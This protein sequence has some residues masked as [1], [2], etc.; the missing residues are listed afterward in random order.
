MREKQILLDRIADIARQLLGDP[1]QRLSTSAQLRF[2]RNGSVAVETAGPKAGTWFDH[3]NEIGG[4]AWDLL[5][6]KG[7]ME[8]P[9]ATQW[10]R[11]ELGIDTDGRPNRAPRGHIA[12]T[13]DYLDERGAILFQVV[14]FEPKDFRQRRPGPDGQWIWNIKGLRPVLYQLPELI[15]AP[16][17]SRV[18][19][20]EGE[21]DVDNLRNLGLIATTS[22]GG[23]TKPGNRSKWRTEYTRYLAGFDVVILPDNDGA[24]RAHAKTIAASIAGIAASVR[25]VQLQ[26]LPPKGDVSD[27]ISAGGTRERLEEFATA[28]APLDLPATP[29]GA[30]GSDISANHAQQDATTVML[31]RQFEQRPD[32]L[33]WQ[34]ADA[35]KSRVHVCSPLNALART[36]DDHGENWGML[37]T[38][39]DGDGRLHEWPMPRAMLAGDGVAIR[40]YL[41]DRGLYVAPDPPARQALLRFLTAI[42]PDA[43]ARCVARVGW[44]RVANRDVFVLPD[45]V[46]G[47]AGERVLLQGAGGVEHKFNQA[48]LLAEWQSAIGRY[49]I[50]NTRLL[51]AASAAFAAPLLMLTGE[52]SGGINFKG[53]SQI[54][55]TTALRIAGSVWGGDSEPLGYMRQWRATANGLEGTAAA[56]CDALLALDE[57]GQIDPREAGDVAYMLANGAGKGRAG[58]EGNA[59]PV[60]YW[61][62]F[63]LS[64]GE[65]SLADLAQEA[66]RRAKAGQEVRLVDLPADLENGLGVFDDLHDEPSAE[67]LVRALRDATTRLYGTPIRAF[68]AA[69]TTEIAA[70][71]D[72]LLGALQDR[73]RAFIEQYV[74]KGASGQVFSVAGRFALVA[75]AGELAT[76]YGVTGW[77]PGDADWGVGLCFRAWL[78]RRGGVG[79]REEETGIAQVRA[80]IEQHGSARFEISGAAPEQRIIS[81][82]G[83]KRSED[84]GAWEYLVLP[85]VWRQ[86]VCKGHD[87]SQ[88]A[89][90]LAE[91]GLLV[92]G[93]EGKH[94]RSMTIPG[95]KKMRVYHLRAAI[96]GE[97][98]T[99]IEAG[100]IIGAET[101][102]G[103]SNLL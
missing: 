44:H 87:P 26:G 28:A 41:L 43:T 40:E 4:G 33:W 46:Y 95:Y 99:P 103:D 35:N 74:P 80:F 86:E 42:V 5:R 51:L 54:G 102:D 31:A 88:I 15:A 22:P 48:G 45:A 32:G 61:R 8:K 56:H 64:T 18:Y 55:K 94:S 1:N 49:C 63:I 3:E 52:Q 72:M 58:R 71:R 29:A 9:A 38:W 23:A 73:R 70:S 34:P 96:I 37:L 6:V 13:Y 50:G 90:A 25:I 24:G 19:V 93:S 98:D 79:M 65:T 59:R 17:G 27:W 53:G 92:P 97:P 85:E 78:D 12:A 82:A 77:K 11:D 100:E 75:T 16:S 81:R 7:G 83:F 67:A 36:R 101:E 62:T 57:L 2:G 47:D 10:L 84:N 39:R 89:K 60:L 21:K 91:R 14:R 68:L 66:G 69:L 76:R 20:A 30:G